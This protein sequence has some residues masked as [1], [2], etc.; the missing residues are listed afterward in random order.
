ML[1]DIHQH[2]ELLKLRKMRAMI[3][4]HLARA[5]K[6]KLSY[7]AFLVEL[8]RQEVHDKRERAIQNRIRQSGLSERWTL[9]LTRFIFRRA[10]TNASMKNSPSSIS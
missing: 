4:E 8:L 7:S 9:D 10:S 3:D 1:N 5:Q 6:D 2:L